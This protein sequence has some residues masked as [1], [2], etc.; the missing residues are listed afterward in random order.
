MERKSETR[1]RYQSERSKRRDRSFRLKSKIGLVLNGTINHRK[2][3][4]LIGQKERNLRLITFSLAAWGSVSSKTNQYFRNDEPGGGGGG[5]WGLRARLD[6]ETLPRCQGTR[7]QGTRYL[8]PYKCH[9][10]NGLKMW[11]LVCGPWRKD[12]D[13]HT[14]LS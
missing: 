13:H 7:C 5:E 12:H 11:P 2:I 1:L 6:D 3:R 8:C 14:T 10:P 9:R 4:I